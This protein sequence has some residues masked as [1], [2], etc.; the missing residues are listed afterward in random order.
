MAPVV[1]DP[2]RI[3]SFADAA[4]FEEWLSRNHD[5]A[6]E[7]WLKAY[8]KGS[9][10]PSVTIAEALDVVLCWGWIDGIRKSLDDKAFLQRYSPRGKKSIWSQINRDHI[11]RLTKAGRMQPSGLAQV[12]AAKADGRWDAAYAP[13][14]KMEVPAD[15]LAAIEADPKALATYR[16]LN[17]QNR[18][19]LAF[20]LANLKTAAGR[21]KRVRAFVEMLSRG[22]MIYPQKEKAGE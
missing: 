10:V 9:G 6:P 16:K 15:L 8:K 22:E 13:T 2:D 4:A 14:S 12:E 18:F 3:M 20:R 21:E 19:A 11:E 7:V 1:P 17:R 5:T